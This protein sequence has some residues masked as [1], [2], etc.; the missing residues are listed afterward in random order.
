MLKRNVRFEAEKE[1][2]L[3]LLAAWRPHLRGCKLVPERECPMSAIASRR[4]KIPPS[5]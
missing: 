4:W 1:Q 5:Y 3:R 2:L